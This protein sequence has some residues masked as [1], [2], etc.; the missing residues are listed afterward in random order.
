ML[1][2]VVTVSFFVDFEFKN[3][4]LQKGS[5]PILLRGNATDRSG[6]RGTGGGALWLI[7]WHEVLKTALAPPDEDTLDI[8]R[9]VLRGLVERRLGRA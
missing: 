2:A 9:L 5:R 7:W 4:L 1:K 3:L 8:M 6:I